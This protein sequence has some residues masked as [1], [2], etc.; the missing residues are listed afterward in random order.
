MCLGQRV[1]TSVGPRTF[2][3]FLSDHWSG[4]PHLS[5]PCS[6]PGGLFRCLDGTPGGDFTGFQLPFILY[7]PSGLDPWVGWGGA[8]GPKKHKCENCR[9][10]LNSTQAR[11][12]LF[13]LFSPS[14]FNFHQT[15][16]EPQTYIRKPKQRT[17]RTVSFF[18]KRFG[19]NTERP[20]IAVGSFGFFAR[21]DAE[22]GAEQ[23]MFSRLA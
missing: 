11:D 12:Y 9:H 18:K 8:K 2:Q 16:F 1:T 14:S 10:I 23:G 17:H 20:W 22:K 7:T 5:Q 21:K 4:P 6:S 15:S 13:M 19:E 3:D